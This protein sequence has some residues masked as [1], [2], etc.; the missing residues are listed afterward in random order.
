LLLKVREAKRR[1]DRKKK[2]LE[3]FGLAGR[4]TPK[5]NFCKE[6]LFVSSGKMRN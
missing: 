4:R 2:P 5:R 1:E 3:S 6:T